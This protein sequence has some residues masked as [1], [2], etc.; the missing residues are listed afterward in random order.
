[1]HVPILLHW[2]DGSM[3]QQGIGY[4][5]KLFYFAVSHVTKLVPWHQSSRL[6]LCLCCN[7]SSV[8]VLDGTNL[9]AKY[10]FATRFNCPFNVSNGRYCTSRVVMILQ[11]EMNGNCQILNK[12]PMDADSNMSS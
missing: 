11:R 4:P 2:R 1:M 5:S 8:I 12:Y 3:V 7:I 6:C 10:Q 9:W